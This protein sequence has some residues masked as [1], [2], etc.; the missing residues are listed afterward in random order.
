MAVTTFGLYANDTLSTTAS[1]DVGIIAQSDL[2]DG[3]HDFQF[4]FGSTVANT[5]LQTQINPGVNQI[6]LTP[7]YIL[8][9]RLNSTA[10]SLG[11][12]VVPNPVNGYRYQATTAGTSGA[13]A[14]TWGTIL[15]GTTT[16]GSVIWTLVAEDS[17]VSEIKLALTQAA[18]ASATG[19]ASLNL[20][21][22]ILSG[23]ADAVQF[24]MRVTNTITQP[25]DTL[26]TPE[27]GVVINDVQEISTI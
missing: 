2:S 13:S 12:S 1:T 9:S 24:W 20:G 22:N 27:L 18:L 15:N 21:A 3:A 16:D 17:P 7:A 4:F 11:D 8:P 19:G 10:Y 26:A 6:T 25:S 23:V 14:P 5:V